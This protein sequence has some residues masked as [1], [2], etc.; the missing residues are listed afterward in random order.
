MK[1]FKLPVTNAFKFGHTLKL[2]FCFFLKYAK[3][4]SQRFSQQWYRVI[5]EMI[6]YRTHEMEKLLKNASKDV[7]R[8]PNHKKSI[9]KNDASLQKNSKLH[10]IC[11]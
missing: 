10:L 11:C 6:N 8:L 2:I 4:F 1:S 9:F 5:K 7:L 3:E